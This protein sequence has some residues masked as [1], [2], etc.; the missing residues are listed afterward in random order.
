[1]LDLRNE[2]EVYDDDYYFMRNFG[3]SLLKNII[4]EPLQMAPY[5]YRY[6]SGFIDQSHGLIGANI[7]NAGWQTKAS[8]PLMPAKRNSPWKGGILV[9]VNK[10]ISAQLMKNLLALRSAGYCKIIFDGDI[11]DYNNDAAIDYH[12]T[13]D[14]L[15]LKIRVFDLPDM[16][17]K[18]TRD[19]DLLINGI[20]DEKTFLEKCRTLA[21]APIQ[22]ASAATN[23]FSLDYIHPF[24]HDSNIA[25]ASVGQRLFGLYN[26]WN[27]IN[28][29]NPNKHLLKQSWD[30]VLTEFIPRFINAN[31]TASYY[32]TITDL[33]SHIHDSH[34]FFGKLPD[35]KTVTE[36]YSYTVPLA[37]KRVQEK[38]YIVSKDSSAKCFPAM[39]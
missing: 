35:M 13:A 26:Y 20:Q 16:N 37:V 2:I 31:D 8:D 12:T 5:I 11:S 27:A 30:S 7:Y 15:H 38:Y 17:G 36:N 14:N 28:Y 10:Y 34:G 6:Q 4:S 19:P 23:V 39:G 21:L 25:F 22:T 32:F 24:P 18:I 33:V 9:V 29:F 3:D 1:M